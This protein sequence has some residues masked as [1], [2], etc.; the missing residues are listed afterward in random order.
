MTAQAPD[1]IRFEPDGELHALCTNPLDDLLWERG[2]GCRQVGWGVISTAN[3]RGYVATFLVRKRRLWLEEIRTTSRQAITAPKRRK[4]LVPDPT[5]CTGSRWEVEDADGFRRRVHAMNHEPRP[6]T[7]EGLF[8]DPD[9]EAD[10][11]AN[12]PDGAA[13]NVEP[14]DDP[15]GPLIDFSTLSD[16]PALP[17]H[18]DEDGRV[19][20]DWFT[21]ELRVPM[22]RRIHYVHG[23]Y[24][25][26]WERDRL[27]SCQ[28]GVVV[29]SW[30]REN[31]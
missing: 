7:V 21:G 3:W 30:V 4:R 12:T 18:R 1:L 5:S 14:D 28:L 22:G 2:I 17:P 20:C 15:D 9:E 13:S 27:I 26:T 10:Q 11:S 23:G 29:R 19:A 31:G 25:S 24:G 6:F 8:P 16:I